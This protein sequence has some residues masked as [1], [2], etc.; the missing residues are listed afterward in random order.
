MNFGTSLGTLLRL[1]ISTDFLK[2]RPKSLRIRP[3]PAGFGFLLMVLCGFLLSVNFSNNLIFVMTFLLVS[4][5]LV[6]WYHTW[7][8]LKGLVLFD[9]RAEPVFAG[10]P[11]IFTARVDNRGGRFHHGLRAQAGKFGQGEEQHFGGEGSI[12]MQLRLTGLER[13]ISPRARVV[14]AS[15]FPLGLFEGRLRTED[16]PPCLVYPHPRGNQPLPEEMGGRQAHRQQESGTYTDMRRYSPGDPLTRISWRAFAR[17]D[18]LYT[19]EFDGAQGLPALWLTWDGVRAAG[20]EDKLGQLCRWV[21]EA[22]K[23]NREYG[24]R[25]PGAVVQPAGDE[26][27]YRRCLEMLATYGLEEARS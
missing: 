17:F 12:D 14:V 18:E 13:G 15:R 8:N 3:T 20:I 25:L 27:H 1:R 7:W 16:L 22:R 10:Q 9:W 5:A 11:L 21:V 6:S 19:K 26:G 4:I 23:Q 24:M 2:S